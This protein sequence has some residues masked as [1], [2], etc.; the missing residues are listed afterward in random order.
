[1][2]PISKPWLGPEEEV[3]ALEVLISGRL[4]KGSKTI[5]FEQ[6]FADYIG[7]KHAIAVSSGTAALHLVLL[8]CE[9][10]SGAEVITTPFTFT[11][12][13]NMI[14][15]IGAKP[16]FVDIRPDT[17]NID[18]CKIEAAITDKTDAILPVHLFGTP[19]D[20]SKIM[21][22]AGKYKL[23]IIEDACQAHGAFIGPRKVGA[24]GN[25]A[26]FSFCL[27]QSFPCKCN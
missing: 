23:L 14:K 24:F 20:M 17:F 8:A 21:E 26:C 25:A 27:E 3:A 4:T 12:T 22:I 15:V 10:P 18:E 2:I 1:M 19:C 7:T 9:I 11:A 16:V 13:I 5:E 6:S